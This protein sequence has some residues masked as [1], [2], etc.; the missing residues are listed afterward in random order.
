M[1]GS[2]GGCGLVTVRQRPGT[3]KGVTFVTLKEETDNVNLIIWP[4]LLEKHR[5]EALGAPCSP[6][7]ET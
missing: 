6:S 2:R 7:V 3:T 4:S 1:D 5:K